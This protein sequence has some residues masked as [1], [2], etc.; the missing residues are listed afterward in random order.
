MSSVNNNHIDYQYFVFE[1]LS[2]FR[3]KIEILKN[4]NSE[5][6]DKKELDGMK[7]AYSYM[8]EEIEFLS[9]EFQIDLRDHG[10]EFINSR[11]I[12]QE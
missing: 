8:M 5:K 11:N 10:F 1:L 9:K 3:S 7:L 12:F 6:F 2:A 4:M